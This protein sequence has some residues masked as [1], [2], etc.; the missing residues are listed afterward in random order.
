MYETAKSLPADVLCADTLKMCNMAKKTRKDSTILLPE[1]QSAEG[2]I[3]KEKKRN[4][5]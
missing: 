2:R 1:T 3:L 5:N 4:T